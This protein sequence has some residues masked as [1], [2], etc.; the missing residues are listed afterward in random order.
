MA[1]PA[2]DFTYLSRGWE[3]FTGHDGDRILSGGYD[4][5]VHPVDRGHVTSVW[6][7]ACF[8]RISYRDEYRLQLNDGSY[9]W[10]RAQ[11][12]PLHDFAGRIV[13]WFGTLVDI[14]ELR[15]SEER[16]EDAVV[17]AMRSAADL[18]AHA[19]FVERLMNASDDCIQVLDVN[20]ALLAMS[21]SGR[22]AFAIGGFASVEGTDWSH[23]GAAK[24][25][26]PR[27]R[28]STIRMVSQISM[29]STPWARLEM[30]SV[31]N[32]PVRAGAQ[33]FSD[34]GQFLHAA[35]G[36]NPRCRF[37][38]STSASLSRP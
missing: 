12:D 13:G 11:A 23:S 36:S 17:E 21:T 20:S 16:L 10:V 26:L 32:N 18:T 28:P 7:T 4:N 14:E 31:D 22:E 2:G 5:V 27:T 29:K 37:H 25:A 9:R 3:H 15:L 6:R 24:I 38:P 19:R 33:V 8:E 30:E 35:K 1:N 34:G